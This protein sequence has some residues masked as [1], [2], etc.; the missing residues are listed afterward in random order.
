MNHAIRVVPQDP[1]PDRLG[2]TC[3]REQTMDLSRRDL[4]KTAVAGSFAP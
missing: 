4:L 1:G 2:L 3:S